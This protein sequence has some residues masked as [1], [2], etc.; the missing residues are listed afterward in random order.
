[1]TRPI[2]LQLPYHAD[3]A[4]WALR[5]MHEP[6]FVWLDSA[7]SERGRYD[8]LASKPLQT[9][10]IDRLNILNNQS[11]KASFAE[12]ARAVL[13]RF[14][15]VELDQDGDWPLCAGWI[16]FWSYDFGLAQHGLSADQ[17]ARFPAAWAG[18]YDWVICVDHQQQRCA[19]LGH[20]DSDAGALTQR[21]QALLS[22]SVQTPQ[23]AHFDVWQQ[24][25]TKTDYRRQFEQVQR[26][27]GAGDCYQV[28]LARHFQSRFDGEALDAYLRLRP[29]ARAPHS[30]FVDTGKGQLLSLSPER[31]LSCRQ[32]Q[33]QTAPIKGTAA[34]WA[35]AEADRQSAR[36]LAASTKNR[37]ENLMIVDLLRN[38]LGRVCETGSVKVDKLFE[39]Q[40][41][42]TVHHLVSQVSGQLRDSLCALDML[43]HCF[44]GGS[45]TGA[46]KRRAMEIIRELEPIDRGP[47]CGSL[48]YW[49]TEDA[50]DSNIAIRS[51]WQQDGNMHA[52]A[53]GGLVADSDC[54]EEFTET[55][56]K[57]RRL[58]SELNPAGIE[59]PD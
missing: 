8:I 53:G 21:H 30:G 45:I 18:F 40:T 12:P 44:P 38:D 41:F 57:I 49:S 31:F 9:I 35:D 58:L 2:T 26:F 29:I 19:L 17:P 3:S 52:W 5:L 46:P 50:L 42:E 36:D 43:H 22:D 32:R 39:L 11:I 28:N 54:D 34:R 1:M 7:G 33:V 13:Q 48:F 20:P 59:G 23:A 47:Y 55:L 6:G 10:A 56:S 37:A 4:H 16:G 24:S 25:T 14:K 27:I 51:L 15:P